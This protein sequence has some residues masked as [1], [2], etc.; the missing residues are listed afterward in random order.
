[1]DSPPSPEVD[2]INKKLI[3]LSQ[4]TSEGL[5]R[6][7]H[8]SLALLLLLLLLFVHLSKSPEDHGVD[9]EGEKERCLED[10]ENR[11]F[12]PSNV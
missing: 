12:F 3:I 1:M 11:N 8:C 10:W 4:A 2:D 6:E 7:I 5:D 9:R